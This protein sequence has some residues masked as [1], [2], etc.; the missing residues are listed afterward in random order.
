MGSDLCLF[1]LSLPA[2]CVEQFELSL[3][4]FVYLS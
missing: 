2:D 4:V 3:H 1:Q